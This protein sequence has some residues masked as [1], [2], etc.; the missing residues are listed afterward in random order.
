MTSVLLLVEAQELNSTLHS[1]E[2]GVN[3]AYINETVTFTCWTKGSSLMGWSSKE[4]IGEGG[5]RFEFVSVDWVGTTRSAGQ[6][7]ARLSNVSNVSGLIT[8]VSELQISV[9]SVYQIATIKCHNFGNNTAKTISFQI[10]GT[11]Y[12]FYTYGTCFIANTFGT[13]NLT[14]I[15]YM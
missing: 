3:F 9:Q 14:Y 1:T 5:V 4:Y 15:L 2:Y 13:V 10:T 8:M 12:R 7:V 11:Q 6:T